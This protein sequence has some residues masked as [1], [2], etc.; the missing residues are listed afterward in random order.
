M[1]CACVEVRGVRGISKIDV[2][3]G[4]RVDI[5]E[6]ESIVMNVHGKLPAIA[7]PSSLRSVLYVMMPFISAPCSK[8]QAISRVARYNGTGSSKADDVICLYA[9]WGGS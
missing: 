9:A 4:W 7:F 5:H 8:S 1:P 6:R 2:S 3:N